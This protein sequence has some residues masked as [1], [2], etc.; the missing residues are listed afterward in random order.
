MV[1]VDPGKF[2]GQ[3]SS[4]VLD[5][6]TFRRAGRPILDGISLSVEADD[7]WVVLGPNGSGKTTLLRIMALY[8]HPSSG[9]VEILGGKLGTVDVRR[10]RRRIGYASAALADQLR[11]GLSA[12][13]VVKTARYA[14]LEPWWHRYTPEDDARALECLE[15]MG[16]APFADRPFGSLSSGEQQRVLLARTLMNDPGVVLLDEPSARLDLGGREELL[17]TLSDLA[18]DRSAPPSVLVT[19]HVSEIPP[20]TTHVLLLR[21]GRPLTSGPIELL[22]SATLGEC[23]HLHVELHRHDNGRFTAWAAR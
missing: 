16:V 13:D 21:D 20:G 7:R 22:T 3:V 23:F 4:I 14:A 11:P 12:H 9:S 8:E 18:A 17:A 5:D 6:I 2:D 19:H 15:R 10:L 1:T